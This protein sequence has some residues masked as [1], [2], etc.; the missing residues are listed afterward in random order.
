MKFY[1]ELNGREYE[2]EVVTSNSGIILKYNGDEI[3]ADVEPLPVEGLYHL[4]IEGESF[5][6]GYE[7]KGESIHVE[8]CGIPYEVSL[9]RAKIAKARERVERG[10]K[11]VSPLSGLVVEI[12][13]K[14]GDE[15][16]KGDGIIVMESMKM[17]NV[18]KSPV[19]GILKELRVSEGEALKRGDIIGFV[20]PF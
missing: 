2:I 7:N 6:L 11:I 4:I 19:S 16:E 10:K 8:S 14:R 5:L 13:K 3:K 12:L 9:R 18:I 20:E 1:I 15:L 17:R